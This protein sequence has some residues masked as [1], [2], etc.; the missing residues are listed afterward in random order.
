MSTALDR[1]AGA[2]PGATPGAHAGSF[3][4]VRAVGMREL[5]QYFDSKIAYV[6]V[7]AFA[8]LANSM[9]MN[10]FFLTGNVDMTGFFDLM[11]LLLP[12]FLPALTMRLYAEERRTRTIELLLTLPITPLLATLGKFMA[13]LFVYGLFLVATVPIVMMLVVLG[14]PDLGA[15]VTGYVGLALCGGF[16]IALGTFVSALSADQIV[17]FVATSVSGYLLVF[18]GNDQVVAILDGLAPTLG[19]GTLLRDSFSLLPHYDEFVRGVVSLH[20][21]LYFGAMSALFLWLTARV[22]EKHRE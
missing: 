22:L 3:G 5:R 17:T 13:A 16:L 18:S 8:L 2:V 1:R 9:F 15:I 10:E 7:I 11:P 12:L 21:V 6:F 14:S 19:A 20:A 4:L